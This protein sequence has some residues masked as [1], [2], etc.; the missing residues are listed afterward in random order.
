[1][2]E[3]DRRRVRVRV[4]LDRDVYERLVMLAGE[5][6]IPVERLVAISTELALP[7]YERRVRALLA[8]AGSGHGERRSDASAPPVA[9]AAARPG[10]GALVSPPVLSRGPGGGKK[11]RNH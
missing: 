7:E 4:A 8:P 5:V 9:D 10:A 3:E 2:P 11:K 6:G 1:M